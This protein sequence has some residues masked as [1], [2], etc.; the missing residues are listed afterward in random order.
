MLV[1]LSVPVMQPS[2]MS[3]TPVVL[4]NSLNH[5]MLVNG[6]LCPPSLVSRSFEETK[7][8]TSSNAKQMFE[9][10]LTARQNI[11]NMRERVFTITKLA[12]C[13]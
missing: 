9:A 12:Q 8:K 11:E 4:V 1:N 13:S 7:I 10:L 6:L 3:V 5:E 2:V